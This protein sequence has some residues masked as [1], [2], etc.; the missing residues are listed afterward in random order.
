MQGNINVMHII[1]RLAEQYYKS[2]DKKYFEMF[3][4]HAS[5]I[6]RKVACKTCAGSHWDS[7][8][9]FSI[10]L[11]DMWRLFNKY[12]P[13]KGKK[14]H[15]LM[16]RQLKNKA[17]NYVHQ[18][19]GHLHKV[20]GFCNTKQKDGAV[21][22][23][24]CGAPLRLTDIIISEPFESMQICTPDC[25]EE[26]AN[27]QLVEKL[28]EEVK[29]DPKT[30]QILKMLLAGESKSAISKEIKLA[31]NAMNNR[32]KKCRRIVRRLTK[33]RQL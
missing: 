10:L 6:I 8:E 27:K 30:F 15:W 21:K 7:E 17:I 11:A 31:Q 9:L 24:K 26:F 1:N 32:I 18:S 19:Q 33:E 2:N 12:V 20:C 14:F 23:S 4:K 28:L 3:V 22:C 29:D 16:L 25:L 5:P 13:E